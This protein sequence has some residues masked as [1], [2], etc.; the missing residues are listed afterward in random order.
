MN[1]KGDLLY[2]SNVEWNLFQRPQSLSVEFANRGYRVFYVEPM[3]SL[4]NIAHH[5]LTGKSLRLPEIPHDNVILLRPL[6]ALSTFRFGTTQRL[7]RILFALWFS[8]IKRRYAIRNDAIVMLNLP[9]WWKNIIDRSLFPENSIIYD[10]IDDTRVHSRNR[11]MLDRMERSERV[12]ASEADVCFAT[13]GEL[14]KKMKTAN[15]RTYLLPNAVSWEHFLSK[16]ATVPAD[17]AALPRPL[18]GFVG[19]LYDHIDFGVFERIAEILKE[20]TVVLVGFTNREEELG[21]LLARYKNMYYAGAK[22]FDEVPAYMKAFD[23]CLSPFNIDTVGNSVNP[24]KL[25][26]Y[27]I[28]GMP[29]IGAR[30]KEMENYADLVYLYSTPEEIEPALSQALDEHRD[31]A[32]KRQ[33]IQFAQHNSWQARVDQIEQILGH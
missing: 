33:R 21:R 17:L 25:Y 31:D 8:N 12:L 28:F 29:I 16:S 7:D 4:G 19:S 22:S 1:G 11:K 18:V 5:L 10:C 30:T 9:Y 32:R 26:E 24:L 2:F 15:P 20:G 6:L 3:L 27:S 14:F 13:A 23:V